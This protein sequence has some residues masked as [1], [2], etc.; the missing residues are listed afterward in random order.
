MGLRGGLPPGPRARAPVVVL[1]ADADAEA[2]AAALGA[3]GHLLKPF[4]LGE[5]L[6]LVQRLAAGPPRRAPAEAGA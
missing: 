5:L 6:A 4:D 2:H 3:A 1:T